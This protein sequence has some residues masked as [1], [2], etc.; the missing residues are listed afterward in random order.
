MSY[1]IIQHYNASPN[2][3]KT[4]SISGPDRMS[5]KA[6]MIAP[7]CAKSRLNWFSGISLVIL[8]GALACSGYT[9]KDSSEQ[10]EK[11]SSAKPV[12]K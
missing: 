4:R 6:A 5:L 7:N 12:H 8:T 2:N 3:E 1:K 10:E 9:S 11:S